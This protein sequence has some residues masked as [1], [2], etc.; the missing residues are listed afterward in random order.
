MRA[1]EDAN[2]VEMF[3]AVTGASRETASTYVKQ[4]RGDVNAAIAQF[5]EAQEAGTAESLPTGG[6]AAAASA[7]ASIAA[8]DSIVGD[9]RGRAEASSG[10]AKRSGKGPIAGDP[11]G[12][13]LHEKKVRTIA[14]V[15]FADGFMVDEDYEPLTEEES[16]PAEVEAPAPR[17]TGMMNLEDLKRVTKK[18]RGP[19]PKLPKLTELRLYDTPENKIFLDLVK[20][21]RVPPELQKP[22]ERGNP[23]PISIAI[24]DVRPKTYQELFKAI[25]EVEKKMK[26]EDE[27]DVQAAA[28]QK[29]LAGPALFAGAGQ[30]LSSA[31]AAGSAVSGAADAGTRGAA[32]TGGADT[33]LLALVSGKPAPAADESKPCTTI[34]IRLSSG[35]RVKARLNLHHTVA[36]LWWLVAAQMGAEAFKA[37]SQH[38]LSAGFPP[39]PLM[40]PSA[41]LAAADLLNAAVTHRC[42]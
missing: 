42:Q 7:N 21:S 13:A 29:A 12:E 10:A 39:K 2:A 34:Q 32:G 5:F 14:I 19:R 40:D 35:I 15:F 4:S 9:A 31:N 36:D 24:E 8:V 6:L 11:A 17:R 38:E 22:D 20:A 3:M 33:K 28:A 18:N 26:E 1:E 23:M 16:K 37:A 25:K 30:T 27:E 41:S